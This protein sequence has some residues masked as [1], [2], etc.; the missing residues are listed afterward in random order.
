MRKYIAPYCEVIKLEDHMPL[1]AGS[2]HFG[3]SETNTEPTQDEW[4]NKGTIDSGIGFGEEG[5]EEWTPP[6]NP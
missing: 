4:E 1:L 6:Q 3:D 5:D 2:T